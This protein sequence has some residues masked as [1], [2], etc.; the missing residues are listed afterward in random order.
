[1]VVAQLNRSAA[2]SCALV[3]AIA[4]ALP[5]RPP[6][7]ADGTDARRSRAQHQV[8]RVHADVAPALEHAAVAQQ[9]HASRWQRDSR[10][11]IGAGTA[12][13]ALQAHSAGGVILEVSGV[14]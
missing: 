6:G 11:P 7:L 3:Q 8:R 13:G 9:R 2:Q 14:D 4:V 10:R 5:H 1:M 12:I